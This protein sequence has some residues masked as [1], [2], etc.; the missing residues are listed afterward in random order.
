MGRN[1]YGPKLLRADFDMCAEM[2]RNPFQLLVLA[3]NPPT[4]GNMAAP[5]G[6]HETP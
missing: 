2:T 3:F 6:R 5:F 1:G 4:I